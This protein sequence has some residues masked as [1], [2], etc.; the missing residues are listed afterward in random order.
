ME[1]NI[2]VFDI[3][4]YDS[5]RHFD[6][7]T[8]TWIKNFPDIMIHPI[9]FVCAIDINEFEILYCQL[10]E[11]DKKH[12]DIYEKSKL[13][14]SGCIHFKNYMTLDEWK[15]LQN[16]NET[17]LY[18]KTNYMDYAL[19]KPN[20]KYITTEMHDKY[21]I[22]LKSYDIEDQTHHFYSIEKINEKET[23]FDKIFEPLSAIFSNIDITEEKVDNCHIKFYMKN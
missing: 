21:K 4:I 12:F 22:F 8:K 17:I 16:V 18:C 1:E 13:K 20:L 5:L 6:V 11:L 3:F 10:L 19:N 14:T 7:K 9:S 2:A 23:N 15:I